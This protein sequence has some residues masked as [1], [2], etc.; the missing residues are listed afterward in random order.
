VNR[1]LDALFGAQTLIAV[2]V[3]SVRSIEKDTNQIIPYLFVHPQGP[4][5]RKRIRDFRK[6]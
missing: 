6:A 2:A 5:R 1:Q 3:W 4:H